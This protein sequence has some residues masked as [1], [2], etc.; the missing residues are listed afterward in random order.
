MKIHE[1]QAKQI[2]REAG[3]AVPRGFVAD[4]PQAAADAF[5]QLGR[6]GGGRQG[7]DPRRRTRQ[8]HH[9]GQSPA[10]AACNWS[11]AARRPKRSPPTCSAIR[12]SPSRP[13][14]EGQ[15]RPPRAGRR[16][17]LDRPRAVPGRSVIDRGGGAA[18]A[19]R[20]HRRRHGHRARRRHARRSG[21]S[22]EPFDVDTG[23]CSLPGPQAGLAAGACR[24]PA[25]RNA[26][27]FVQALSRV[28][29]RPRLQPAGDQSRWC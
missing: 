28:V 29:P 20:F 24:R 18:G 16:R 6:A 3:V 27:Q 26:E 22:R 25:V 13:G 1:F 7:P 14:P 15:G 5:V 12:W 4:T 10:N 9:P 11:A 2:L 19:D 23:V 17:L 8:G 21:S